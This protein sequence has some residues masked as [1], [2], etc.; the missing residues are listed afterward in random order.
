MNASITEAGP[1]ERLLTLTLA[2][3]DIEAAK[4]KAAQR[5]SREINIKGFR[6]GKAP[7]PIVEATVGAAKLRT[8]AI[9]EML[10][11]RV[12]EV[13]AESDLRPA[14]APAIEGLRDVLNGVE[15][16]V[17]VTLWPSLEDVPDYGAR[18]VEIPSPELSDDELDGQITRLREQYASLETVERAAAV[19]D[20]AAIDI[21]AEHNGLP[22]EDANAKDLLYE[23][24]SGEFIRGIDEHLVGQSAGGTFVF[25]GPL[26][27]GFGK[28]AGLPVSFTVSVTEVK[29][30]V[31]AELTDEWVAENT[32]FETVAEMTARLAEQLREI[33]RRS[34]AAAF[35][36]LAFENLVNEVRVEIPPALLRAEMDEILHR[37]GHRLGEQGIGLQDYLRVT[38]L[39]EEDFLADLERQADRTLRGQL[40][41]EAVVRREG[42]AVDNEEVAAAVEHV[43][44]RS[45]DAERARRLLREPERELALR[46]DILR[47][48]ALA[49]IVASA[50]PVD[51][52]GNPVDLNVPAVIGTPAPTF[53]I[54]EAELDS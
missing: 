51:A 32:E 48:K 10:P 50:Q 12:G 23:V 22:V 43:A 7:R 52:D 49:A 25:G 42:L 26:P 36:D 14:V 18:K 24:G 1:F 31:L 38:G 6:P 11:A 17:R 35:A 44:A 19:G 4:T 5:L 21:I 37:F 13:L 33:K 53:E 29:K 54:E 39:T 20:Y 15:V 40:L 28:K 41:L 16:D 3:A 8:E 46:S 30:K 9:E 47:G 45:D 2:H 34:V 27:A